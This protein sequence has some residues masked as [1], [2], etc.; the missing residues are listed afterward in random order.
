[1]IHFNSGDQLLT[2]LEALSNP[3]RLKII[4]VLSEGKQYVSQLARELDI[5]RPLLYLHL[6]KLEEA[7]IVSSDMEIL[8]SGKAV[9][10]YILNSFQFEMN[11][12]IVHQLSATLT[13]KKKN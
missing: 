4:S 9:K 1:M 11:E 13:I 7:N 3:Q 5:S 12:Q 10:Y 8:E 6:K 2:F